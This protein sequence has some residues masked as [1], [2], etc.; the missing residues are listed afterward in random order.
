[1]LRRLLSLALA[2]ALAL[3]PALAGS[4]QS[5]ASAIESA[6]KAYWEGRF[7]A[8]LNELQ[9]L[10][11]SLTAKPELRDA[12]FLIG[13][14]QLAFGKSAGARESFRAAVGA[15]PSFVPSEE[16]YPP[17]VVALYRDVRGEPTEVQE[18][19]PEKKP[20]AAKPSGAAQRFDNVK[21]LL[22]TGG[23]TEEA[24]AVLSLED[25]R[26]LV[27]SKKEGALL[28]E[29]AYDDIKAAQ[30]TFS[31]HPR[32]KEGEGFT[33]AVGLL[34]APV[35]FLKGKKHWLTIQT[36]DDY[37]LLRLDKNNYQIVILALETKGGVDVEIEGES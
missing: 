28:K 10:L 16:L 36:A 3:P 25:Q 33:A 20:A 29:I 37:A 26:L 17:D 12:H 22:S 4:A 32:W 2:F 18:K 30:Y 21:L 5:S 9:R 23:E 34:A 11:P 13:L 35:F 24:E 27:K 1:M 6:R 8:S 7:E 31:R 14:N 15:D 19:A